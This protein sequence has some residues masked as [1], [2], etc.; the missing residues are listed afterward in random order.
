MPDSPAPVLHGAIEGGGTKFVCA[1]GRS[2][3]DLLESVTIATA[4]AGPAV[5]AVGSSP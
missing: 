2:P 3:T 1:V 4:G 5:P